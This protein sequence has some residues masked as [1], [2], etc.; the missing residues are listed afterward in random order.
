MIGLLFGL[1]NLRWAIRQWYAEKSFGKAEQLVQQYQMMAQQPEKDQ[2]FLQ[3]M[4]KR[5]DQAIYYYMDADKWTPSF[6]GYAVAQEGA[7]SGAADS[8]LA[9][10]KILSRPDI[11][12]DARRLIRARINNTNH[13]EIFYFLLAKSYLDDK[14]FAKAAESLEEL[15]K[16]NKVFVEGY[17]LLV[18][19]YLQMGKVEESNATQK[20]KDYWC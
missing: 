15:L 18:R 5:L 4:A 11:R 19:V 1:Y 12:E 17:S 14:D 8:M 2:K 10:S 20:R 7:S 13:Q 9:I 6:T 3:E 16:V